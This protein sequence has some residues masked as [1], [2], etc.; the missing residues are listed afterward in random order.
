L[1]SNAVGVVTSDTLTPD[2]LKTDTA[3][4]A[5]PYGFGWW[6]KKRT[7]QIPAVQI[8]RPGDFNYLIPLGRN[9]NF[10]GVIYVNGSVVV[11]GRLRGRV[12]IV[13]QGTIMLADDITYVT[14]PGTMCNDQGDILGLLSADSVIISDNSIQRPFQSTVATIGGAQPWVKSGDLDSPSSENYHAFIFALKDWGGE[15]YNG[16]TEPLLAG[17]ASPAASGGFV[18][19]SGGLIQGFVR[20]ATYSTRGGWQEAH[21]YDVCG[22]TAP[23]PYFPT[24]GRY[25]KNRYYELDPVWL[26]TM[27]MD[28]LFARLQSQ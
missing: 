26:N 21:T 8:K 3:A 22:A 19:V 9:P 27:P 11:S 1:F 4:T 28:T 15:N 5:R 16:T 2:S 24:T 23:P 7:A 25:G 10:K 12:S 6:R 17:E 20:V 14:T 18:R 13:A